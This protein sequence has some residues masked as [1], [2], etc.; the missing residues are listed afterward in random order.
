MGDA[1]KVAS[2]AIERGHEQK[3]GFSGNT[4]RKTVHFAT[5]TSVIS[6]CGVGAEVSKVQRLGRAPK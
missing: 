1:R 6:K 4:K 2:V 3:G 5:L